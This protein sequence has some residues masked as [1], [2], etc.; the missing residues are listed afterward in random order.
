MIVG[1][2]AH[3]IRIAAERARQRGADDGMQLAFLQQIAQRFSGLVALDG[4]RL[5][6]RHSER[7]AM[8]VAAVDLALDPGDVGEIDAALVRQQS[9]DEDRSR[10]GVHRQTDA[11]AFEVFRGFHELTIDGDEAVPERPR[12][13]HRDGDERALF[14]GIPRD[15]FGAGVFAGVEF[16]RR[17]HTVED[18]AGRVDVDKVE[19]DAL[20]GTAPV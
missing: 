8:P 12:R 9:L 15:E 7:V 10:H 1:I 2:E 14:R 3:D 5:D 18:L 13:K 16:L 17:R 4:D 11:S 20:D 19:I 6:Q